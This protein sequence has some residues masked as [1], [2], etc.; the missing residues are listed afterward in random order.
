MP[1]DEVQ[2]VPRN[3]FFSES[4]QVLI[5]DKMGNAHDRGF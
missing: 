2:R 3:E 1:E 4:V 5:R